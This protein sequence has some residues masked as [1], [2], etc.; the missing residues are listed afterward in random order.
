LL[1]DAF[2]ETPKE[3]ELDSDLVLKLLKPLYGLSDAGDYWAR[4]LLD[5]HRMNLQTTPTATDGS[6]FFLRVAESLIGM[7]ATYV[8]DSL[9]AGTPAFLKTFR[10]T[11]EKFQSRKPI[12]EKLK[13]AG[14][15]IDAEG[16][17]S[18]VSKKSFI[19]TLVRL[20]PCAAYE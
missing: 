12:F 5:H 8:D 7:F 18:E 19:K 11:G 20:A 4:T 6:L 14:L 16:R 15:E 2:F 1:R 10:A 3:L 13:F 17:S 9:R